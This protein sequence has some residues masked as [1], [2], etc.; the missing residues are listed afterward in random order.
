RKEGG[1]AELAAATAAASGTT[2]PLATAVAVEPA[3]EAN[4]R[5]RVNPIKLKQMQDRL[6]VVEEEI[7]RV[8]ALIGDAEQSLSVFVSVEETARVSAELDGLRERH[9][10]LTSEWEEL[11]EQ[12]EAVSQD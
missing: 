1:A 7:P 3:V 4:P 10:A 9:A 6:K 12:L 2:E 5:K 8:E 11:M